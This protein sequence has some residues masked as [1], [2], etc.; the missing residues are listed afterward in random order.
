MSGVWLYSVVT[1]LLIAEVNLNTMC[2][3]G[4]GGVSL[5]SM[6]ERT[7]GKF[8]TRVSSAAYLF[9]HYALLV[10]YISRGGS[11]L[12]EWLHIPSWIGGLSFGLSLGGLCYGA[13]T[14][15]LNNANS[16]LVACVIASFIG[17]L[18][19][20]SGSI[21]IENL[22]RADWGAV[23]A[24]FSILSL[25]FVYQ[26]IV[27][28]ITSDLEGDIGKV[29][30]AI[31]LGTVIPLVMFL[32]WNATILGSTTHFA[33]GVDPVEALR[34]SV[35]IAS[36]LIKSF[37][38]FALATSYIGFVLGL[39]DFISD[40]MKLPSGRQPVPYMMVLAPSLGLAFTFPDI[41]FKALDYAG[42]YGVLVLFGVLPAMMAWSERYGGTTVTSTQIVQGG[43]LSL[44]CIGGLAGAVILAE[45]LE[46]VG[47]V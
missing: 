35:P 4:S 14:K 16:I 19:V 24:S 21:Q 29:R 20:G 9:L 10:A 17:L 25:A 33:D 36:P 46:L 18:G 38:I 2:E 47:L 8:G 7:L 39:T 27:P 32:A 6:A 42:T 13:N 28:V 30:S 45:F 23:P 44:I 3:L 1:G 34:M 15:T 31:L 43:R 12:S 11:I 26:N 41:F 22:A 37:S 5:T 40:A